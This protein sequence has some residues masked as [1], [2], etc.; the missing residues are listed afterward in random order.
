MLG[1]PSIPIQAVAIGLALLT[2]TLAC[3][4]PTPTIVPGPTFNSPPSTGAFTDVTDA[5]GLNALQATEVAG[6]QDDC[7][8]AH[9]MTAAVAVAD[10]NGDGW[11]DLYLPRI[12]LPDRLMVNLGGQ[13][14]E[15]RAMAAGLALTGAGGGSLFF[16]RDGDGD[17]DLLRTSPAGLPRMFDNDGAGN[18]TEVPDAAG[19]NLPSLAE[20]QCARMF[21]V[22]VADIDQD[23]DLDIL[24]AAWTDAPR[25]RLFINDGRGYFEDMSEAWGL[26]LDEAALLVPTF[27]DLDA[28]GDLDLLA[29]ADFDDT[30]VFENNPPS[31][32]RDI[33]A[34]STL[35]R[36]HDGMGVDLGDIDGD[37]DYDLFVSGICFARPSGCLD[38][39]G[40]TGN[41][42]FVRGD[43]GFDATATATA[44]QNA[45]WAWGATFFDPDLD[46]DLD[47]AVSNGYGAFLEFER[48]PTQLFENDGEGNFTARSEAWGIRDAGQG[49]AVLAFDMDADGDEDLLVVKHGAAPVLY[50]NDM[51]PVGAHLR[52]RVS[53]GAMNPMGIGAEVRL[54]GP[55]GKA[56]YRQITGNSHF[57]AHSVPQA[58]FGGLDPTLN[59]EIEVWVSGVMKHEARLGVL[60]N[61]GRMRVEL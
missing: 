54:R 2:S 8:V 50:R 10:I 26:N 23:G 58:L 39:S 61:T 1:N 20:G 4:S 42:L 14:F 49:R 9:F 59:Y 27:L 17:Q 21:G 55:S 6:I 15:D 7:E 28:D 33:T 47:L 12:D 44:I 13:G 11:L 41:Q 51:P 43:A 16:D 35:A 46:G 48:T 36:I 45:G 57:G 38:T 31:G 32:F 25:S 29:A 34:T 30:R 3:T 52:V 40:W 5:W 18:F 53:L 37:G 60:P 22:S 19:I 56:M 24:T